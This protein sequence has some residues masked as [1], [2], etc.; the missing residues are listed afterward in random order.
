MQKFDYLIVGAGLFGAVFANKMKQANKKCL[1]IDKRSHIAGNAYTEE[2]EGI[3]VHKYGAHI[4]H[5]KHKNVWDF[6]TN[7]SE[8]NNYIHKVFVNFNNKIYSFPI[9]L[10]TL[11]QMWDCNNPSEAIKKLS[12]SKVQFETINNFEEYA[13]ANVGRELYETFFEG[14]TKKQWGVSPEHLPSSI[15]KRI[16][17]RTTLNDFYFDDLYQGIPKEGYTN[18]VDKMLNGTEVRLNTDFFKY[19]NDLERLAEKVVFTGNIDQYYN[20]QFGVL[21]YRSLDFEHKLLE[22][23]SYQGTSVVNYTSLEIPHT[24]IIEHKFF[25][26]KNQEKTIITKEFSKDWHKGM[27][28]YYPINDTINTKIL[29]KYTDLSKRDTK[30]IFGGRLGEY[31]YYNMDQVILSALNKVEEELKNNR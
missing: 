31:K 23:E 28:A 20:Y 19:K 27:D 15:I 21:S 14:Y 4:F 1:V 22:T 7:F 11:Y 9:N 29:K 6:V 8:F 25:N 30:I 5:T 16:P 12:S 10:L 13:L 2:T 18:M 17:I 26:F 3:H 24:R